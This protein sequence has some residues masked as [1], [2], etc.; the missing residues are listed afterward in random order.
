MATGQSAQPGR[1]MVLTDV[2]PGADFR[3]GEAEMLGAVGRLAAQVEELAKPGMKRRAEEIGRREGAEA[4]RQTAAG[5]PTKAPRPLLAFG[6]M[7]EAR[8]AASEAAYR[9]GVR[10]DFDA[11]E[12]EIQREFTHDPEA[13][14]ERMAS[15]RSTFIQN[16][17]PEYAVDLEEYA[18][19]RIN[20]GVG[21]VADRAQSIH[22]REEAAT[23]AGRMAGLGR[24]MVDDMA[25]NG[26]PTVKYQMLR[27]EYEDV[28][29]ARLSNPAIPYSETEAEADDRELAVL[30]KAAVYTHFA[31][32]VLR[33][34]GAPAA[35]ETLQGIIR[36][37]DLE[38]SE[39][40]TVFERVRATINQ[41]I[42]LISDQANMTRSAQ[43]R[44]EEAMKKRIEDSAAAVEIGDADT[45]LSESEVMLVLGPSGV[46]DFHRKR[47]EA[48]ERNRLTG[49][50]VGLPADEAL[51]RA[52]AAL[53]GAVGTTLEDLGK[54]LED[55]TAFD[56]LA[57]A[58]QQVETGNNPRRISADPDGSGG[59]AG[60][61]VGAM[62]LKPGTARA[63]ARRLGIPYD[64]NRLL[65]DVAY[66]QQLGREEI[67]H[68]LTMYDGDAQLAA[69]AYYA[70]PGL[71]NAWTQPVG[72]T[73]RVN[74]NGEWK[75]VAGK[76]DPRDGE[77]SFAQW[78]DAVERAGN[79]LSAAYP[80]KV[81]EA[82]AGGRGAAEWRETQAQ[83]IVN[84][85]TDGFASDPQNQAVRL[86]L[87]APIILPVDGVFQGGGA[88][89]QWG[90]AIRARLS[91]GQE[92]ASERGVPQRILTNAEAA[93]YRDRFNRD[94]GQA[95]EFAQQATRY[96]G[97]QGAR[98]ALLEIR[99]GDAAPATIHIATLA[100][101]GGSARFA[102]DAARG[103]QLKAAG[104]KL[105]TDRAG[106]IAEAIDAVRAPFASN[107][108]L[109]QAIRA[110]AEAAA[111]ADEAASTGNNRDGEY[112]AQGAVG[113]TR[114]EGRSYGGVAD[115]NGRATLLPVWLNPD[116][117]ED[118]LER[119]AES[120]SRT[121]SGPVYAND[122]PMPVRVVAG[123]R[124]EMQSN[125]LYRLI[126][127]EGRAAYARS[128]RILEVDLEV[129]RPYL[130]TRLGV[131]GVKPD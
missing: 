67:R 7:A 3:T 85:A 35:L 105:P 108:P 5:E 109:L 33:E 125:G 39:R 64:E 77:I 118:A 63:A 98:D 123:L 83:A 60:G 89:A 102:D 55:P 14:R 1:G 53:P 93:A 129:H 59:A 127:R 90:E 2:T 116:R 72:A 62:Q 69:T 19:N 11:R 21:A 8:M 12:D 65:N 103:L 115:V 26:G 82:L 88:A 110:T 75:N 74:V 84:N 124:M 61:A 4:A 34:E 43:T 45:G 44:A 86:R 68:L 27:L 17:P 20:L 81:A 41:E 107:P 71:V 101:T 49:Q 6:E 51:R 52:R 130:A 87:A 117:A 111:L 28:R 13:Y 46:A 92:L 76:G 131:T 54:P 95:V 40:A 58:I 18:N 66:N 78:I 113:R 22:L 80:R 37:E 25:N 30:G 100:T 128:G 104:E 114:W 47:A 91:R 9:A 119:L 96:L 24:Q 97:G 10:A 29:T 31:R 36:D 23:L 126:D 42:D 99:Q 57:A 121:D 112:Y 120:W 73:T 50:L 122:T 32:N 16:A 56:A 94:P 79:P 48:A 38:E 106:E 15:V 70:G